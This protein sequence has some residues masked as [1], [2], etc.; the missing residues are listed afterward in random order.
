[1]ALRLQDFEHIRSLM[2]SALE[3]GEAHQNDLALSGYFTHRQL[4]DLRLA[5]ENIDF[6]IARLSGERGPALGRE[7]SRLQA[8][9]ERMGAEL[10]EHAEHLRSPDQ[11]PG[12]LSLT[13]HGVRIIERAL[14]GEGNRDEVLEHIE[15]MR[16]TAAWRRERGDIR[17]AEDRSRWL[18][19]FQRLAD[20]L[21]ADLEDWRLNELLGDHDSPGGAAG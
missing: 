10:L 13:R 5:I 17:Y 2:V 20:N 21:P 9:L 12:A 18:E 16:E 14:Q 1:M 4:R 11:P 7:I 15:A 6:R 8:D 19:V 3:Y